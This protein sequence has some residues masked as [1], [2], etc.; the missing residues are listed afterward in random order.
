[1]PLGQNARL[2]A[3]CTAV[4]VSDI[5]TPFSLM[6]PETKRR[7]RV[8]V[9]SPHSGRR[10]PS[11]FVARSVLPLAELSRVEDAA[12]DRLLTFQPLPAPLLMAGFPRSF[13]DL[14]RH[15]NEIDRRMFDAPVADASDVLTRYL[16]S[17][18]GVIPRKAANQQYIYDQPLPA[19]EAAYRLQNFYHPFHRQLDGL[20]KAA[21]ADAPALLIDCHSMPSNMFG[22]HGDVIIGNNHGSAAG[23]EIVNEAV[24]FF[25]REGLDV[26]LNTPFA[27]GYITQHYGKPETGISAL[28]I[29]I[30]RKTYLDETR[31]TL[32]QGW[33]ELASILCR[34]ILRMDALMAQSGGDGG[35]DAPSC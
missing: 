8:V 29:E 23:H 11:G 13:V 16:R 30:A 35:G 33:E 7:S 5:E 14:N 6:M 15:P 19:D 31:L 12:M 24:D 4:V 27:G 3:D 28:Q 18:L 34:F 21:A 10:Y 17:G 32:K 22:V 20:L 26:R 9:T 25:S 2:R 1:M